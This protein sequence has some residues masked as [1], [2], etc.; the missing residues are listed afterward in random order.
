MN[1][2]IAKARQGDQ[3]AE[4]EI[5]Q[6][7]LARFTFLASRRVDEEEARDIAQDAC[8][9][10]LKKYRTDAPQDGFLAWAYAVL[11]R[12]IGNYYQRRTVRE[13]FMTDIQAESINVRSKSMDTDID[14][15]LKLLFCLK[16]FLRRYPRFARVLNLVHQGYTTAEICRRLGISSNNLY[17]ILNRGRR[18]LGECLDNGGKR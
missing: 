15:R 11:R 17:V 14:V 3:A 12:T 6:F 5:F 2:L 13:R 10:V 9:T 1:H 18:L 16:K 7:L 4:Q 8:L